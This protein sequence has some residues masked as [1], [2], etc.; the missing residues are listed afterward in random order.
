LSWDEASNY[1]DSAAT[2]LADIR[3]HGDRLVKYMPKGFDPIA[4]QAALDSLRTRI[5]SAVAKE[6]NREDLEAWR[7]KKQ[8]EWAAEKMA[9]KTP[10]AEGT[11]QDAVSDGTR[12]Q[13]WIV[14]GQEA[15]RA[16]LKDPSPH[17]FEDHSFTV[18]QTGYRCRVVRS[19]RR[20]A[21][22]GIKGSRETCPVR[23]RP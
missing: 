21:W 7:V 14:K 3:S 8:D 16:K 18:V 11:E 2:I 9:T 4:K 1:P 5:A 10:V 15:V 22:E 19:T 12:E 17:S 13:L 23:H 20:T 6:Q